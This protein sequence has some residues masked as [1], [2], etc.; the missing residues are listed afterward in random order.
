MNVYVA[1]GSYTLLWSLSRNRGNEWFEGQLSY[2]SSIPHIIV[3]EA[4]AGTDYLVKKIKIYLIF[5][6]WNIIFYREIFQLM[7][8]HLQQVIVQFVQ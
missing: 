2:V 3:V 8:L 6:S 1:N 5:F 7:I 4:V